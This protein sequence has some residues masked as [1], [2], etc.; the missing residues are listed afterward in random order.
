MAGN[1]EP[2]RVFDLAEQNCGAWL[3]APDKPDRRPPAFHPGTA[4]LPVERF[5]QQIVALAFDAP[6]ASDPLHETANA[7]CTI[8]GGGNSRFYWNIVQEG[9]S[10]DAA[11]YRV[12]YCDAGLTLLWGQTDADKCEQLAQAMQSQ[13]DQI[14]TSKVSP[15]EVQRVKNKRRTSL[16]VESE[17]PYYRLLQIMDDVDLRGKPRTIEE[18]LAEVDA[19]TIDGIAELFERYPI[20]RDGYFVSVGPRDWP[21]IE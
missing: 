4:V 3:T 16:A 14:C 18:R 5:G 12:P 10:P 11:C 7:A 15:E 2:Q 20:N 19:V 8:L 21:S 9:V 1:V 17:A 6:S 13:A